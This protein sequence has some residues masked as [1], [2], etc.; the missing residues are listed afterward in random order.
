MCVQSGPLSRVYVINVGPGLCAGALNSSK[1]SFWTSGPKGNMGDFLAI[2]KGREKGI[3][4]L[5]MTQCSTAG[6]SPAWGK[7]GEGLEG[8]G[9]G[10]EEQLWESGNSGGKPTEGGSTGK[11]Y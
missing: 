5:S 1:L 8:G 6:L 11:G 9:L 4:F 7:G 10:T 2:E 3:A